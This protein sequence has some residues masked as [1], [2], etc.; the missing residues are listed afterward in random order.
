MLIAPPQDT[1]NQYIRSL[2]VLTEKMQAPA[3]REAALEAD[4]YAAFCRVLTEGQG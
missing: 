3:L 2:A 1:G 4:G